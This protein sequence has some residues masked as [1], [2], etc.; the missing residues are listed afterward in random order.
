VGTNHQASNAGVQG[1][2]DFRHLENLQRAG[3][4]PGGPPRRFGFGTKAGVKILI[5][6]TIRAHL[7]VYDSASM[8]R[9]DWTDDRLQERFDSIDR[10]F[11]EVDR[12][13]DEVDRRFYEVDRHFERVDRRFDKVDHELGRI[14]SRMDDLMRGMILAA[15][16]VIAALIGV[17]ATQL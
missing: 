13:F 4:G 1:G 6:R 9:M 17:I 10:R 16:G 12:R 14:N 8:Y 3:M 7:S 5:S 11:D 15:A 2:C